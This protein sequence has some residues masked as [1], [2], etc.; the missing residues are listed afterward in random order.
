MTLLDSIR[1][2]LP[3]PGEHR[4][5]IED[6]AEELRLVRSESRKAQERIQD[7]IVPLGRVSEHFPLLRRELDEFVQSLSVT[8][9]QASDRIRELDER[10]DEIVDLQRQQM[11]LLGEAGLE[12]R[13]DRDRRDLPAIGGSG[14]LAPSPESLEQVE[15]LRAAVDRLAVASARTEA[16]LE[17]ALRKPD[18]SKV[19]LAWTIAILSFAFAALATALA[20]LAYIR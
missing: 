20:T 3:I 16:L 7:A 18:D 15:S 1:R 9:R 17:D 5:R 10:L 12:S 2:Y 19:Q 6:L 14:P 8:L 4:R 11:G 13:P